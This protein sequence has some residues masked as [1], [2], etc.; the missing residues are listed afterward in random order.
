MKQ[1]LQSLHQY[2]DP[3][4]DKVQPMKSLAVRVSTKLEESDFKGA[5]RLASSDV[6]LAPMNMATFEALKEKHP[7]LHPDSAFPPLPE[8]LQSES[9]SVSVT[10]ECI[11]KATRS[12]PNG[13]AGGPDGLRPQHLKDMIAP[14]DDNDYRN[15]V[16]HAFSSFI[17][18]VLA[19]GTISSIRP[20]FFGANL[21][22]LQKKD[23]GV[24]PIAVGF[25]LRR[26]T[27]KVAG[28]KLM[29]EMGKLLAPRQLGY[30]VKGGAE[31]AVIA[32]RL[33]LRDL[34][35]AKAIVKL[36]FENAF[37]FIRRDK[38]MEAVQE[39]APT[40]FCFVHSAYSTLRLCFGPI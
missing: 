22:A 33:Y 6:K 4:K 39:L 2:T 28:N 7:P 13:S 26:L 8:D 14:P 31:A 36:D 24:R 1:I 18:L 3:D 12:F 34:N 40:L 38:M 15:A 23:G 5:V 19:G 20:Y 32:A 16:R 11:I 27:A 30:G 21:T 25:T 10:D 29:E 35:P 17:E 9:D 37:N